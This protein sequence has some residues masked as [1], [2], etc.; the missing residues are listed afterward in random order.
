MQ[1]TLLVGTAAVV[2]VIIFTLVWMLQLRTRNAGI[3]DPV[4]S[5]ALGFLG[6]LYA[7]LGHGDLTARWVMGVLAGL[8][9]LRLGAHLLSRNLGRPEDGRYR[10]LREQWGDKAD[11]RMFAFFM[12]QVVFAL[13]LS[14]GFLVVAERPDAPSAVAIL[15]AVVV[16]IV[17][18][19]GEALADWQLERFRGDPANQGQVCRRGLWNY[20][21]H[22]NYFFECVHWLA[23]VVLAIG[24]P[25]V[26]LSLLPP[27]L[28]AWLLMKVSGIPATEAQTARSRPGYA[29]YIRTTSAL[30]PWLPRKGGVTDGL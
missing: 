28:M 3:V 23:Y 10:R 21:R 17:S 26:W 8:W 18:V 11:R 12:I 6:I 9:G 7:M 25:T 5:F 13:L 29:D 27:V 24:A 22:P 2:L 4:W 16:W 20:S 14:L 30:I 15:A 1:P 19:A